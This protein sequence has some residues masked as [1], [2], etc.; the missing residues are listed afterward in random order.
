MFFKV[1]H[2]VWHILNT[3]RIQITPLQE[4]GLV[5][6]LVGFFNV[7]VVLFVM[8]VCAISELKKNP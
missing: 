3:P 6:F 8:A 2:W 5:L 7:V 1:I 4:I